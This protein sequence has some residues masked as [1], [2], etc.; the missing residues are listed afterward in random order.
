MHDFQEQCQVHG[1]QCQVRGQRSKN[2]FYNQKI[3]MACIIKQLLDSVFVI[4]GIITKSQKPHPI[5]VY[6]SVIPYH[7]TVLPPPNWFMRFY[8]HNPLTDSSV[9]LGKI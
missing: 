1:Q 8:T 4:S 6:N 9:F 3:R 5:I 7:L 2:G